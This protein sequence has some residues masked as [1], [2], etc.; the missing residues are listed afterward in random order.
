MGN[1]AREFAKVIELLI[2]VW[3]KCRLS[4]K[5]RIARRIAVN[6]RRNFSTFSHRFRGKRNSHW[7]KKV[8]REYKETKEIESFRVE[9]KTSFAKNIEKEVVWNNHKNIVYETII[10]YISCILNVWKDAW[11]IIAD[12]KF[13]MTAT[14]WHIGIRTRNFSFILAQ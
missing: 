4:C 2:R 7:R 1:I 3:S 10:F 8:S 9:S 14:N 12:I 13:T 5:I 11:M 6:W